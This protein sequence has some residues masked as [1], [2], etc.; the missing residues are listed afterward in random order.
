[1]IEKFDTD[2]FTESIP[3]SSW[4]LEPGTLPMDKPPATVD[5]K[6]AFYSMTEGLDKKRTKRNIIKLVNSGISIQA[7]AE[8]LTKQGVNE[9]AFN[10][11]LA[12][13]LNFPLAM[14]I[15][16]IVDGKVSN[17]KV[18]NEMLQLEEPDYEEMLTI[19][20]KLAPKNVDSDPEL[21]ELDRKISDSL[22]NMEE[23]TPQGF[24]PLPE[25]GV[26]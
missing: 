25:K 22:E 14:K 18:F 15:F 10:P 9:G 6:E 1:M 7:I 23:D 21:D 3:G 26:I 17:I 16:Q 24:M 4:A 11:D 2:L 20:E 13:I 8:T 12:E 19:Q 5:L